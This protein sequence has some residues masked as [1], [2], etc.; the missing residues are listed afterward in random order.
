M[1]ICKIKKEKTESYRKGDYWVRSNEIGNR[2]EER[3]SGT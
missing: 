3:H 1:K 2:G